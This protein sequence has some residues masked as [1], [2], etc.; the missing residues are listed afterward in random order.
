[1]KTANLVPSNVFENAV[2]PVSWAWM[3]IV[4]NPHKP[5]VEGSSPSLDTIISKI[6]KTLQLT[7]YTALSGFIYTSILTKINGA[8]SLAPFKKYPFIIQNVKFYCRVT[9][10]LAVCDHPTFR[11]P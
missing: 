2:A 8:A 9:A 7:V 11:P 6:T 3:E 5:E 4:R 1:M 10:E